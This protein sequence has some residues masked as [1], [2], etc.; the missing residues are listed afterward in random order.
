MAKDAKQDGDQGEKQAGAPAAPAA[1]AAWKRY[2]C[3]ATP[4]GNKTLWKRGKMRQAVED[5]PAR[6]WEKDVL[7]IGGF[8]ATA[9]P[10]ELECLAWL[11]TRGQVVEVPLE[12]SRPTRRR[13]GEAQPRVP[14]DLD[15]DL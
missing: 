6:P 4:D 8:Y 14:N 3:P 7:F 2:E 10:D 13:T 11:E 9:D 5:E 15:K 12:T 1:A